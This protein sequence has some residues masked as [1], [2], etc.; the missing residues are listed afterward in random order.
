MPGLVTGPRD[1]MV[2]AIYL[3]A[4]FGAAAAV[5]TLHREPPRRVALAQGR[6][7][8]AAPDR[9]ARAGLLVTLGCLRT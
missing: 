7:C 3:G 2:V 9:L 1:A 6:N 4:F 8:P 5:A